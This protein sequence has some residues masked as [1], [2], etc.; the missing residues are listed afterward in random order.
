M[1]FLILF[2]LLTASAHARPISYPEG[3]TVMTQN[4]WE[5]N[6]LHLHYS[7]TINYSVGVV[8]ER[9]RTTEQKNYN[10]QLNNLLF[11]KNTLRSQANIY[12]M[13]ELGLARENTTEFNKT[14]RLA[15]DWE[16][17]RYFTSYSAS[18]RHAGKIDNGS[19]HQKA[20]VGI[21]PYLA[22]FGSLHTWLMLQVEHHPEQDS[23]VRFSPLVR[24]FKGQFLLE[25][26]VDSEKDFLF[27]FIYR[28]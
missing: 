6:R 21:A 4:N 12:A 28:H 3:W 19:F 22:E 17:R 27:N 16:T 25:L 26:G 20:R 7:P 1:R 5:K 9:F 24:F 2:L 15:G 23:E 8:T 13:T 14:F 18:L 11:R 10:F